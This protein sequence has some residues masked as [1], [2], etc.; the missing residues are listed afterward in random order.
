MT[1]DEAMFEREGGGLAK[2][3]R[4]AEQWRLDRDRADIF[5]RPVRAPK[6]AL[7]EARRD[8]AISLRV[9]VKTPEGKP[10]QGLFVGEGEGAIP[11][12]AR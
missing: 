12:R 2:E 3:F 7:V 10:A 8:C 11:I 6:L 9:E 4:L 1:A 5:A